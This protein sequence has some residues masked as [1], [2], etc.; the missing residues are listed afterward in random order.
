MLDGFDTDFFLFPNCYYELMDKYFLKKDY[1]RLFKY[2]IINIKSDDTYNLY[3]ASDIISKFV[4]ML[5]KNKR[6]IDIN[7]YKNLIFKEFNTHILLRQKVLK[8]LYP[9]SVN[10]FVESNAYNILIN[11][12][13]FKDV[14][15]DYARKNGT[16]ELADNKYAYKFY[17]N[18]HVVRSGVVK[19]NII[20][21]I[22]SNYSVIVHI[23]EVV[24]DAS[25][26]DKLFNK[27]FKKIIIHLFYWR[28]RKVINKYPK[29]KDVF[30][31]VADLYTFCDYINKFT[32]EIIEVGNYTDLFDITSLGYNIFSC[33]YD[34][35]KMLYLMR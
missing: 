29:Y 16:V 30:N 18:G 23:T 6:Y 8:F 31:G 28:N 7:K 20:E 25:V 4:N 1:F 26:A 3:Q 14:T 11:K 19:D 33:F 2:V 24:K 13:N 21:K 15:S 10:A 32:G 35:A 12:Y 27:F 22:A 5:I 34:D 9:E 17:I